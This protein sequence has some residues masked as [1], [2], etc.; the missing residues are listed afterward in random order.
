MWFVHQQIVVTTICLLCFRIPSVTTC[1]S[2][3]VSWRWPAPKMIR[4]RAATGPLT[5]L[6]TR[7]RPDRPRSGNTPVP[8][9]VLRLLIHSLFLIPAIYSLPT[10]GRVT[11]RG[12][13]VASVH[14]KVH[15]FCSLIRLLQFIDKWNWFGS[16]RNTDS[17]HFSH[18]SKHNYF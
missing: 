7:T 3:S 15:W 10:V 13:A 8:G 5:P 11:G 4:A 1:R 18:I 16:M 12:R 14:T 9:W 17:F 2:I 6:T